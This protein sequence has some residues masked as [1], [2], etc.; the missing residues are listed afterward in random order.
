MD[1]R[2]D[3]YLLRNCVVSEQDTVYTGEDTRTLERVFARVLSL[4]T[5]RR[6]INLEEREIERTQLVRINPSPGIIR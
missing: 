4:N 6:N 1:K 5:V 2:V 3:N